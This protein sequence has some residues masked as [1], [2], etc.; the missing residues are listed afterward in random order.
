MKKVF[1]IFMLIFC[2]FSYTFAFEVKLETSSDTVIIWDTFSIKID[3]YS[4]WNISIED[5]KASW[6]LDFDIIWQSSSTSTRII[7]WKSETFLSY[8]Y[9]LL[10]KKI[11]IYQIWPF[12]ITANWETV[13][14]N[15]FFIEVI[16]NE[17]QNN[18]KNLDFK[19]KKYKMSL[20]YILII[21]IFVLIFLYFK[22][23]SYLKKE[24]KTNLEK[25]YWQIE[26]RGIESSE[27]IN[28][29]INNLEDIKNVIFEFLKFN[30]WKDFSHMTFTEIINFLKQNNY[31]NYKIKELEYIF[32]KLNIYLY[33]KNK[34]IEDVDLINKIKIFVWR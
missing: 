14:T 13:K 15:S 1:I 22:N 18:I 29:D 2:F 27:N 12:E 25:D 21:L 8:S 3:I 19:T 5:I 24:Q 20:F 10:P 16:S 17:K 28:L 34:Q 6:I 26:K 31:D 11:W 33:S 23:T 30:F 4:D 9:K 7:N 32:N